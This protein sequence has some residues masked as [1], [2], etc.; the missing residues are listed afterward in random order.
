MPVGGHLVGITGSRSQFDFKTIVGVVHGVQHYSQACVNRVLHGSIYPLEIR[1]IQ[2]G[3]CAFKEKYRRADGQPD[4]G[5]AFGLDSL[6]IRGREAIVVLSD[7][8][9]VIE[10]VG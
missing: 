6:H 2:L 4:I 7:I 3:G 9:I 8:G 10:P 1:L 5:E